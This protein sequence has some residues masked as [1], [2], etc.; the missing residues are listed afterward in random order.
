MAATRDPAPRQELADTLATAFVEIW[1]DAERH[2]TR[3]LRLCIALEHPGLVPVWTRALQ[4][5]RPTV[6]QQHTRLA[7]QGIVLTDATAA[8]DASVAER[9][10]AAYAVRNPDARV[11]MAW[12]AAHVMQGQRCPPCA[13]R[14]AHVL[15]QERDSG[16]PREYQLAVLMARYSM[17]RLREPTSRRTTD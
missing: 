6:A 12:L 9:I 15:E 17:G 1:D 8:R 11:T 13:E 4:L 5:D 3:I 2:H 7:L 14:L 10:A 16:L